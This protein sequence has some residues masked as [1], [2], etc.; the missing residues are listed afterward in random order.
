MWA[1]LAE[2]SASDILRYMGIEKD[3]LNN[4]IEVIEYFPW[5]IM[6]NW[7]IKEISNERVLISANGLRGRNT[8]TFFS[9]KDNM[10]N[11]GAKYIDQTVVVDG[12][13]VTSPNPH[14]LPDFCKAIIKLFKKNLT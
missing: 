13:I 8:T 6:A 10:I 14:D 3:N 7:T 12:N 2:V 1:K 4:L 11:A 5:T 9:I